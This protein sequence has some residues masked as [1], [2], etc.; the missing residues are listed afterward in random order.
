MYKIYYRMR[1]WVFKV[2]MYALR[3]RQSEILVGP[4][5]ILDLPSLI[6][7]QK[8]NKVLIVTDK[9]LISLGLLNSLKQ[10]LEE[11]HIEF[12]IYDGTVPNPTNENIEEALSMFNTEKCEGIVAFGGGSPMD[13]AKGVAARLARPNKTIEQLKGNIR[14]WKKPPTTFAVPTTAGTGSETTLAA[15]ISDSLTHEK[16]LINDVVLI[17]EFAVLDPILTINLPKTVTAHTGMD[18]LCHA[19]ESFISQTTTKKS[20]EDSLLAIKLIYS[21]L[22]AVYQDGSNVKA[23]ENMLVASYH[24]GAAFT[25]AYVGYV[26]SIAHAIGGKYGLPHGYVIAITLP[27]VLKEYGESVVKPLAELSDAAG[28]TVKSKSDEEKAKSF[29]KSIEKFNVKFNIPM[30]VTELEESDIPHL[31]KLA[32]KEAN[33]LYPVPVIFNQKELEMIMKKMI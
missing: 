21:N 18:A 4:N 12:V 9:Q 11:S 3:W 8:I 23:R 16:Y 10:K 15:V 26:H 28:L 20:R 25:R 14:V 24:A 5:S 7:Q 17:P 29:I 22:E 19:T 33:P 13:C 27:Y 32:A 6:S 30:K 1:Q 2:G 31:A